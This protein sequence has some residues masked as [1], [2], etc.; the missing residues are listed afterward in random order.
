MI[1]GDWHDWRWILFGDRMIGYS[2]TQEE[3]NDL[4]YKCTLGNLQESKEQEKEVAL[5]KDREHKLGACQEFVEDL[6]QNL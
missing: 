5:R 4:V 1:G 3:W 6:E 2:A